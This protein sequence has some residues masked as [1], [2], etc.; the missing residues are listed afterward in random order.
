MHSGGLCD[1][2]PN[3]ACLRQEAKQRLEP[4][5]EKKLTTVMKKYKADVQR[6]GLSQNIIGQNMDVTANPTKQKDTCLFCQEDP[7]YP[8]R[9]TLL[10]LSATAFEYYK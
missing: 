9:K 7:Q 6:L 10:A 1:S 4:S 3:V 8:Q 5:H 2:V